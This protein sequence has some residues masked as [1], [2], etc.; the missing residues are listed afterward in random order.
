MQADLQ[1]VYKIMHKK[2]DLNPS[3]WFED[4]AEQRAKRISNADPR[5]LKR[6]YGQ[7]GSRSKQRL[8]KLRAT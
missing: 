1:M 6:K 2:G 7:L 8:K 5:N 3:D 4:V